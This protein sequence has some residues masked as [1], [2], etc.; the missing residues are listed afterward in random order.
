MQSRVVEVAVVV[1]AIEE[2]HYASHRV[3]RTAQVEYLVLLKVRALDAYALYRLAHVEEELQWKVV[4]LLLHSAELARLL[5]R[6]VDALRVLREA[7]SVH[8]VL[9][10]LAQT[11]ALQQR[12]Y[13]A[14]LYLVFKVA[15]INHRCKVTAN[16]RQYKICLHIFIVEVQRNLFRVTANRRQYKTSLHIFIVEVQRNLFRVTANRRQ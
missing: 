13:L 14:E 1:A 7:H 12:A 8:L 16:R 6:R 11:I 4:G 2:A 10:Q 9:A 15:W 5:Q 3:E